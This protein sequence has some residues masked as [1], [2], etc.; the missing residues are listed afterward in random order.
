[1]GGQGGRVLLASHGFADGVCV[2]NP[3]AGGLLTGKYD[4]NK[5]PA[6]HTRFGSKQMGKVYIDRYWSPGNLE[7]VAKLKDIAEKHGRSMPQFTL[8]W[9]L[10]NEV[11]T[12]VICGANSIKQLEENT[13]ATEIRLTDEEL[14]K[15]DEI[16]DKL[17][18]PRF[19]Y[20]A[21]QPYR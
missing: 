16:W 20:G 9:I 11:I 4:P 2:Y 17:R 18:P 12:S 21:L 5:P 10:N 8:A 19:F 13:G 14:T 15:C 1:M 6:Q 7:A 3:L